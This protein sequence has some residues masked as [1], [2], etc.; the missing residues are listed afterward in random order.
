[1]ILTE[2][3]HRHSRLNVTGIDTVDSNL[4]HLPVILYDGEQIPFPDKTFDATMVSYVLHHCNDISAVLRE[5]KRV[6]TRKLIVFEEI[7]KRDTSRRILKLHDF[8]N[9]FLSTKMNIPCNFLRIEQWYGLFEDLGLRVENCTRIY[10]YP[11][12]NITHQVLFDLTV[13]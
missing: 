5:I 13:T 7:Y 12:L 4:S 8:G 10:Q 3:I 9:R 1:M 2:F 6:T 11:M